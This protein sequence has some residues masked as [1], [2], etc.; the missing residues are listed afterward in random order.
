MAKR[1]ESQPPSLFDNLDMFAAEPADAEKTSPPQPVDATPSSRQ[2]EG[3]P[4]SADAKG[5]T[6]AGP[7]RDLCGF[8]VRQYSAYA[9]CARAIPAVEDGL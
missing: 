2:Q 9:I 4:T 7:L 3:E 5:R 6:G 1:D 8:H